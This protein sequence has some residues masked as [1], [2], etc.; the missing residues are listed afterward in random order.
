MKKDPTQRMNDI[1]RKTEV[2]ASSL[3]TRIDPRTSCGISLMPFKVLVRREALAYR[4][5][6]LCSGAVESFRD[7]QLS[8]TA[9]L[10]RAALETTAALYHLHAKVESAVEAGTVGDMETYLKR[11]LLGNRSKWG[12]RNAINVIA[13]VDEMDKKYNGTRRRYDELSEFAH[14]NWAGT[15][16]LYHEIDKDRGW[17]DFSKAVGVSRN[18]GGIC[19]VNLDVAQRIFEGFYA[20]IADM[21]PRFTE[22]CERHVPEDVSG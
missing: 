18:V 3:S 14:P 9:V 2:F 7:E 5:V 13:F 22:T 1:S 4:F 12:T 21:M 11:A 20:E 8:S 15:L 10:T 19:A 17:V 6:D 16:G